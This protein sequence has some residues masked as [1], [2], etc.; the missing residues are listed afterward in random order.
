ML[1]DAVALG[2]QPVV[3]CLDIN[4]DRSA[5]I[6]EA[7]AT[8]QWYDVACQFAEE[9]GPAMT[10]TFALGTDVARHGGHEA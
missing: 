1:D 6:D 5:A 8:G 7:M 3:L 4:M 9:E 10:G 2:H